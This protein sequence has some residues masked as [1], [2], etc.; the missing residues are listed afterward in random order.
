MQVFWLKTKIQLPQRSHLKSQTLPIQLTKKLLI[1]TIS[2]ILTTQR[3]DCFLLLKLTD[4]L[5][6]EA[7]QS[8]P[9]IFF[10]LFH[11]IFDFF[12][13][14]AVISLSWMLLYVYQF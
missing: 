5:P 8:L 11:L 12:K 6:S 13:L 1:L 7:L 14:G 3:F 10:S 9:H 4:S 2:F